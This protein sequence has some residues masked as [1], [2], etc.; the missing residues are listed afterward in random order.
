M[1]ARKVVAMSLFDFFKKKE[2]SKA[3]SDGS[4]L[5]NKAPLLQMGSK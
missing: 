5:L 3:K 4:D 1:N 2:V